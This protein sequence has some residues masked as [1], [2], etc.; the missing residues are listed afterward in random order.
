M[1]HA[2]LAHR[3]LAILD[4]ANGQQPMFAE[5]GRYAIVFNGEIYNFRQ[6]RQQLAS[7]NVSF[8]TNSDTEVILKLFQHEGLSGLDR[9]R[10]MY[11]FALWDDKKKCGH[12]V[13]D[14]LGIK[15]LFYHL[16][17]KGELA[18]ASEIKALLVKYPALRTLDTQSLHLL[19]NFRYVPGQATM[20]KGAEQVAP[21]EIITWRKGQSITRNRLNPL[22]QDELQGATNS[23]EIISVL[24]KSVQDH[25]ISDVEVGA[26]LSGGID[27]ATIV[28]LA[29]RSGNNGIRTFTIDAGDD[30]SEAKNAAVSAQLLG[31]PNLQAVVST[32]IEKDLPRLIW[33]LE[34]PKINALQVQMVAKNAAQHVKVALSGVGGDELFLGYNAHRLMGLCE[35][36]SRYMPQLINQAAGRLFEAGAR[37]LLPEFWSEPE[38]IGGLLGSLGNWPECYGLL[39]NIWDSPTARHKIYGPR[40]LDQDLN[41]ADQWLANNWPKAEDPVMAMRDFE[42]QHK[43]VNDLLW[44]EDRCSMAEG[45]EVRVPFVDIDTR[46]HLSSLT[47]AQLIPGLKPKHL[48]KKSLA[49]LLPSEILARPKSGFQVNAATFFHDELKPLAERYLAPDYVKSVGLFN[50][51]FIKKITNSPPKTRMR[52]HYFMLYLMLGTHIWLE[53]FEATH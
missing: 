36:T 7:A 18:F 16:T 30:P 19:M 2:G 12:L 5:T 31:V 14:P 47:R 9:L 46:A 17:D 6:I 22:N 52:W 33:H 26:Y 27:S 11:A 53:Q 25:L 50:P 15:P 24:Q 8:E 4:I 34:M 49:N 37:S 41:S 45:L 48:F 35:A 21:G 13:R 29:K 38:R 28:A 43:M 20:F 23:E 10:G 44:Q 39:R 40:M 1:D 3:R 42:W 32:D 51:D